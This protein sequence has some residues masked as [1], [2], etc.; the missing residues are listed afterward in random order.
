M[1]AFVTG[2][3]GFIGCQTARKCLEAGWEVVGLIRPTS[4]LTR[5]AD[6][7]DNVRWVYGDLTSIPDV[8]DKL[9]DEKPDV[10]IHHAWYAEP[11]KYPHAIENLASLN[12][13]LE[14]VSLL[15]TAGC[16][17]FIGIGTCFEYLFD[18]GWLREDS[19]C[20]PATLYAACKNAAAVALPKL[21]E[22]VEVD[23]TWIRLFYQYGPH[24]DTRRLVSSVIKSLLEGKTVDTT[25]GGQVRDFLHV[26]DVGSGIFETVKAELKGIVN[27]GSGEPVTVRAIVETI[28]RNLGREDLVNF[29]ARPYN[30]T[31]PPFVV[32]NNSRLKSETAWKRK[33]S[34]IEGLA[35][36]ID[37]WRSALS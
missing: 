22:K 28:S 25:E 30:P 18:R 29:G 2:I 15:P 37:W 26:E 23:S 7:Q 6:I 4:D 19:P 1:K 11:G 27:V 33:W 32:A 14:L 5:V 36:T 34:H 16:H 20:E 35:D 9:K 17:R 12:G 10:C 13:T 21:S 31:D 3:N 24:E 8:V